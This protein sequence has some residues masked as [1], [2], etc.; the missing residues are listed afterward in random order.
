[1]RGVLATAHFREIGMGVCRDTPAGERCVLVPIDE[2]VRANLV[3]MLHHTYEQLEGD[4]DEYEL[5]QK[6]A[7]KEKLTLRTS[8]PVAD[9]AKDLYSAKNIP[10]D[11]HSLDRPSD[12]AYYFAVFRYASGQRVLGVR[13]AAQFKGMLTARNR[14][15]RMIDETLRVV[16]DPVFRL[17]LD[18]DYLVEEQ[19]ILILRPSGFEYTASIEA[20]VE[21]A[22]AA[23]IEDLGRTL[24][25]VDFASL[26]PFVRSHKRA[27]RMV[28]ALR[29]RAD[30]G[31]ISK[32][33]LRRVCKDNGVVVQQKA[34][35]LVPALGHE[36]SFLKIL[37]RRRYTVS[38]IDNEDERYEAENRRGI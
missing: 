27:A 6:Y 16:D 20:Y 32:S 9:R 13:R 3:S 23:N 33:K 37:D 38:L 8:S 25:F 14:L 5:T 19:Q 18:F 15:V 22:V 29:S 11:S 1:M 17:D 30:L 34:G 36:D 4:R 31:N 35:K 2:S 26:E 21:Q 28:A 7:G 12:I 24:P 10:T